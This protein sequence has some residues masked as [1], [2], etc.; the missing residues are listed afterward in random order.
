M[1]ENILFLIT[2]FIATTAFAQS[3]D[4]GIDAADA[5]TLATNTT[6][7][8]KD[9]VSQVS[10][11]INDSGEDV[12]Y[13]NFGKNWPNN[14]FTLIINKPYFYLFPDVDK[15]LNKFVEVEGK[16]GIYH[17]KNLE[18]GYTSAPC[19]LMT[20]SAQLRY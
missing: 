18:E 5:A 2:F 10:H 15:L 1:K 12:I 13:V 3:P 4:M 16:T 6:V 20:S 8:I 19:I 17:Y 14:S 11:K 7:T 9:K